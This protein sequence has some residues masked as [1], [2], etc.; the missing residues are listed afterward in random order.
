[1]G[2]A[3]EKKPSCLFLDEQDWCQAL[4]V[5]VSVCSI[6]VRLVIY[7]SAPLIQG[8]SAAKIEPSD[9]K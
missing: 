2:S 5:F 7:F 8:N 6:W 3:N 9:S 4:V 1:M